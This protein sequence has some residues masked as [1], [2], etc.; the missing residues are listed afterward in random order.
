MTAID[1][2]TL[3]SRITAAYA[4]A[5]ELVALFVDPDPSPATDEE[6][7][8]VAARLGCHVNPGPIFAWLAATAAELLVE[9]SERTG[10]P[11]ADYMDRIRA[12]AVD[13]IE[14][15]EKKLNETNGGR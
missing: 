14:H 13:A 7:A 11:P 12:D 10:T 2:T 1:P 9:L 4:D 5:A 15:A 3:M 8:R 6:A